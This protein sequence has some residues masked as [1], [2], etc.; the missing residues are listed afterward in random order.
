MLAD[1]GRSMAQ[2]ELHILHVMTPPIL[3]YGEGVLP[4]APE[5]LQERAESKNGLRP[6]HEL[7]ENHHGQDAFSMDIGAED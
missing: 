5:N 3:I 6:R 7:H 2:A 1:E 4:V